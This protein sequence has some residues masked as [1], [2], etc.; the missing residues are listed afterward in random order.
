MDR[1]ININRKAAASL[2]TPTSTLQFLDSKAAVDHCRKLTAEQKAH[3]ALAL[4]TGEL[5]QDA[6]IENIRFE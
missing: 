3:T 5:Y 6:E 1:G 4:A 2:R